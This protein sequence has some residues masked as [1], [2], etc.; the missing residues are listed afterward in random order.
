[1]CTG[2]PQDTRSGAILRV[3]PHPGP[4]LG[5][6]HPPQ[7]LTQSWG[8][9]RSRYRNG[10]LSTVMVHPRPPMTAPVSSVVTESQTAQ[11]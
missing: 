3:R 7:L 5:S 11:H 8:P 6:P 9:P 2:S 10:V 1:M 4:S